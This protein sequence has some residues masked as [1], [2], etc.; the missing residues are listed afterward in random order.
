MLDDAGAAIR[1]T[2]EL[3]AGVRSDAAQRLAEA[4]DRVGQWLV[5][6][7]DVLRAAFEDL[8]IR[9]V[10]DGAAQSHA[11][12]HDGGVDVT[13]AL[14]PTDLRMPVAGLTSLLLGGAVRELGDSGVFRDDPVRV[15]R[16][17]TPV[18]GRHVDPGRA[19][20]EQASML[21][22]NEMLVILRPPPDGNPPMY[23]YA[24]DEY[25]ADRLHDI[26]TSVDGEGDVWQIRL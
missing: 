23:R 22:G 26:T 21:E 7:E 19:L 20:V 1:L 8:H 18:P 5:L 9:I 25:L 24:V 2:T 10:C 16:P 15:V 13:L 11:T 4:A 14:A 17:E 6:W 12:R 3:P